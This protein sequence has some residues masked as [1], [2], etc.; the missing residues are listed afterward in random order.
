MVGAFFAMAPVICSCLISLVYSLYLFMAYED[1]G[2]H[3]VCHFVFVFRTQWLRA[4]RLM[5][6]HVVL[7]CILPFRQAQEYENRFW[8]IFGML[9]STALFFANDSPVA[10]GRHWSPTLGFTM[11]LLSGYLMH[12]V[13][14]IETVLLHFSYL[15][16]LP[17]KTFPVAVP[18]VGQAPSSCTD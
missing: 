6:Y 8:T 11:V 1:S 7:S 5:S 10:F 17:P 2:V 15:R 12:I 3:R 18:S 13:S 16:A 9:L 14:R 4:T